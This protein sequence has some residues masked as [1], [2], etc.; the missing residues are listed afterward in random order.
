MQYEATTSDSDDDSSSSVDD[1]LT[2][3]S[4]TTTDGKKSTNVG[5][6][7]DTIETEA[8]ADKSDPDDDVPTDPSVWNDEHI[9]SW[10]KWISKK[11]S[12]DPELSSLRF[13]KHGNE[14]VKL[15]KA[16]FWV[17]AGSK[18][19]GNILAKYIAHIVQNAT[20][21]DMKHLLDENDPG[22]YMY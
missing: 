10:L 14:L 21:I 20:G 6:N 18:E 22:K 16:E 4:D 5:Q 2:F 9:K 12:L 8:S 15:S 1:E 11:F 17:C 7:V 13:P 3:I 19:A